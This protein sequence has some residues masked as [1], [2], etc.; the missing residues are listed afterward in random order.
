MPGILSDNGVERFSCLVQT[1][2]FSIKLVTVW[3]RLLSSSSSFECFWVKSQLSENNS[4]EA[5]NMHMHV[6]YHLIQLNPTHPSIL[7][8]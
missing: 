6:I 3:R 5:E 2:E 7:T 8:L 1:R 4:M